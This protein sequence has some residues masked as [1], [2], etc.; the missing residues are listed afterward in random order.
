MN[1]KLKDAIQVLVEALK[2]DEGYRISWQAN[3]A[4]AFKDE[5]YRQS[6]QQSEHQF[7]DVHELANT[8]ADN[9]LKILCN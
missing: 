9:F 1:N 5:Y 8:A 6:S 2:T 7:E 4:M 3:I